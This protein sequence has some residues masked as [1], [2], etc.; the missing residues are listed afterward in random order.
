MTDIVCLGEL[1]TDMTSQEIGA[2]LENAFT[3]DK[4]AGGAPANVAAGCAGLGAAVAMI[5][6]LGD[7]SFGH[8]LRNTLRDIE[9]DTTGVVMTRDYATQLAFVAIGRFGEPE[10]EFHVKS[11]AH[12]QLTAEDINRQLV[13]DA[14]VLHFGSLTLV[15]EPARSATLTAVEWAT[16]AG[17]VISF[18]VN[19][20]NSLWPDE[21]SAYDTLTE[22][23]SLCDLVKVNIG[24]LEL[25]TGTDD[26]H[27]GLNALLEMGPEL[28]SVTLGADG[29]AFAAE[30]YMDDVPGIEAPVVDTTG[31]GDAFVAGSLAWLVASE[32]DISDLSG[33]QILKMYR[34]ANA[35]AALASTGAGAIASMPARDEVIDLL[36]HLGQ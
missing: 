2:S 9:V 5:T 30:N 14:L 7:D 12:E 1:L 33:E 18:D 36:K 4:N 16:E 24:E 15:N 26:V 17:A 29:C 23:I 3:F 27:S 32:M 25:I 35:T 22:A 8:F 10:F 34:F 28:A 6:K 19:Y 21:D 13:E 11:P 20:R 31:C